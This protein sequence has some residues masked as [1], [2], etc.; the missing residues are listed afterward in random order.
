MGGEGRRG[1]PETTMITRLLTLAPIVLLAQVVS[2]QTPVVAPPED[3]RYGLLTP[4]PDRG[5]VPPILS[6]RDA[7]SEEEL[8]YRARAREYERELRSIRR[9]HFG[10]IRAPE[11][12]ARGLERL[13]EFVDPAAFRPM[14]EVL[15]D[16]ND[17]TRLAMLD[18]FSRQGD[19]GQAALA[20]MAIMDEDDA[21]RDEAMGRMVSPPATP[22][23]RVLDQTLRSNKHAV[24]NN[25][26]LLAGSLGALDAI[27]LLIF[28]QATRDPRPS[29]EG[30]LAWIAIETQRA[31]VANLLPVVGDNVAA[32][33]PIVGTVSEGIV[34][35][36]TDAV[37]IVYRTEIHHALVSM[38][39]RDWGHPTDHLGYDMKAWWEWYNSEYVP[40]RNERH[41]QDVLARRQSGEGGDED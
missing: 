26:G 36:A 31:Y 3:P 12:R 15:E 21:M 40:F 13:H 24:A 25:A 8:A 28:A 11:L 41:R 27:P 14:I 35:R 18:H 9:K 19:E 16:E 29:D 20:W 38:T 6:L 5:A 4:I 32:F 37:V 33:Q 23:M 34:L 1:R 17:E 10:R 22:V 30:D 39:T 2:A 7:P